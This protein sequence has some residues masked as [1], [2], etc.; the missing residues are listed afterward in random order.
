[1]PASADIPTL[2]RRS[3][4]W[5]VGPPRFGWAEQP[6]SNRSARSETP[7][8]ADV[9]LCAL[10]RQPSF[11]AA[12]SGDNGGAGRLLDRPV[13]RLVQCRGESRQQ[14]PRLARSVIIAALCR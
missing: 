9:L 5:P 3:L 12:R 11:P 7:A 4:A 6:R 1:M 10:S 2:T 14:P 8:P 13:P